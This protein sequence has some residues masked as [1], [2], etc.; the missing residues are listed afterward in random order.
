MIRALPAML[1]VLLVAASASAQVGRDLTPAEK[2]VIGERVARVINFEKD[3]EL[4]DG[5]TVFVL[6]RARVPATS[7]PKAESAYE[8]F[9]TGYN[10]PV[11]V[12]IDPRVDNVSFTRLGAQ[13]EVSFRYALWLSPG[14]A[15]PGTVKLQ[16]NLVE[17]QGIGNE[18]YTTPYLYHVVRVVPAKPTATDL[19]ADFVGYRIYARLAVGRRAEL[20]RYNI[21]V[22]LTEDAKLPPMIKA[23]EAQFSQALEF[24]LWRRRMWVADRHL[25]VAMLL[26]DRAIAATAKK[27]HSN[28]NVADDQ[29]KD[30]PDLTL[31]KE[32]PKDAKVTVKD[33]PKTIKRADGSEELVP[34][35]DVETEEEKQPDST[36]PEK[37]VVVQKEP[38]KPVL[39]DTFERKR[40]TPIPVFHRPLVLDEPELSH[41]FAIRASYAEVS[42]LEKAI[43]PAFFV[44]GQVAATRDVGIELT[45]P[46]NVISV[47]VER[48]R[49]ETYLGN[50]LLALKYRF[51][52]PALM[53]RRPVI[54]ARLRY[55]MPI[56]PLH[57]I[58]PTELGAEDFSLTAHFPD[59]YAFM[60]EKHDLGA[61]FSS[62]WG[63]DMFTFTAQAYVDYFLAVSESR[64]RFSFLSLAYGGGLGVR[65]FGDWLGL[66]GEFRG[67]SFL[68]GPQRSEIF[69]YL[70][71]RVRTAMLEPG[72]WV[73]LPLGSISSAS[74]LQLG[75]ELRVAY[76]V[77]AVVVRGV[78]QQLE[79]VQFLKDDK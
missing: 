11:G 21:A 78:G 12:N 76:D 54:A 65:P 6:Y 35:E 52:L 40:E 8:A 51:H 60:L 46:F 23:G 1:P 29:L 28:L 58:P 3:V 16:L 15:K 19:A 17:R 32:A 4:A 25:R 38:E 74:S 73:S 27:L 9:V 48:T 39:Q 59:T 43:T 34:L 13:T 2:K 62:S 30:M 69:T 64:S 20:A 63:F 66:Y 18:V 26:P 10:S 72:L 49:T 77:D 57:T 61:G 55:G 50:P 24:D 56:S 5:D 45:V 47:D 68:A 31:V 14:T 37:P 42:V 44:H 70:G 67:V 41:S 33:K 71:A 53:E 7:V 36:K 22:A 79:N 75:L